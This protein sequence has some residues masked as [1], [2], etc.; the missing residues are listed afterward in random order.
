MSD[1]KRFSI[2]EWYNYHV[3][4]TFSIRKEG[5]VDNTYSAALIK[6]FTEALLNKDLVYW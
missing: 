6:I 4:L 2:F 3:M 5:T 1:Y